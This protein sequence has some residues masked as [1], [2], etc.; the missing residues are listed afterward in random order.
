MRLLLLLLTAQPL[1]LPSGVHGSASYS[2]GRP[3]HKKGKF[4]VAQRDV[5]TATTSWLR[6]HS[7]EIST[8]IFGLS[9]RKDTGREVTQVQRPVTATQEP[10]V[11]ETPPTKEAEEENVP[12]LVEV[13][14]SLEIA[15]NDYLVDLKKELTMA[16]QRRNET[17]MVTILNHFGPNSRDKWLG[18]LLLQ[19]L[20]D[21]LAELSGAELGF[22]VMSMA[23]SEIRAASVW[24]MLAEA[25]IEAALIETY[26]RSL[27]E[28]A[29]GFAWVQWQQPDLFAVL[30]V[31]MGFCKEKATEEQKRA[32]AWSCSRAQQ[33]CTRLFGKPSPKVD[34]SVASKFWNTLTGL[35]SAKS[36]A[37]TLILDPL[38]VLLLPEAVPARHCDALVQLA[39]V[40]KLWM[41][42][43]QL[44]ASND[45]AT[46]QEILRTSRTSSTALLAWHES[47]PS[48][49]AVREWAARTLQVPEDFIEPLQLERYT[50]GQKFGKHTDWIGEKHPGLWAFGQRM[51]TLHVYL[52]TVPKGAGGETSFPELKVEVSPQKGSAILWPN[53]DATGTPEKKVLH[54]ALP[55]NGNQVKYAM[56]IWVRGRSQPD[57]TW[58][59]WHRS[60]A[61]S[62]ALCKVANPD[63]TV[64]MVSPS[65]K[66]I[67]ARAQLCDCNLTTPGVGQYTLPSVSF[68]EVVE[69]GGSQTGGWKYAE[70]KMFMECLKQHR[71]KPTQHFFEHLYHEMPDLPRLDIVDHVH[72]LANYHFHLAQKQWNIDKYEDE[73]QAH[74]PWS[75]IISPWPLA[76]R[77]LQDLARAGACL[78]LVFQER[79]V[80]D[81]DLEEAFR[82]FGTIVSLHL[83]LNRMTGETKGYCMLE[84]ATFEE[85]SA[86]LAAMHGRDMK[87]SCMKVAWLCKEDG[88]DPGRAK[89]PFAA[90]QR[91]R[92]F[93][94]IQEQEQKEMM[95]RQEVLVERR[96]RD[97]LHAWADREER[98]LG[99]K[100]FEVKD[101][102]QP[103]QRFQ[104]E[105]LEAN[106]RGPHPGY[107]RAPGYTWCNSKER[108]DLQSRKMTDLSHVRSSSHLDGPGPGQYLGADLVAKCTSSRGSYAIVHDDICLAVLFGPA[109]TSGTLV[110]SGGPAQAA[111]MSSAEPPATEAEASAESDLQTARPSHDGAAELSGASEEEVHTGHTGEADAFESERLQPVAQSAHAAAQAAEMSSAEPPA[112]EAEASAESDLQTARPS[113][114]GVAAGLETFELLGQSGDPDGVVGSSDGTQEF[115]Q[116]TSQHRI[117]EDD[118][119]CDG[120]GARNDVL[121]LAHRVAG[122]MAD[123]LARCD[124]ASILVVLAW[125]QLSREKSPRPRP[126]FARAFTLRLGSLG[127]ET[128]RT[129]AWAIRWFELQRHLNRARSLALAAARKHHAVDNATS[130][131]SHLLEAA[132]WVVRWFEVYRK[133]HIARQA[134]LYVARTQ[135]AASR[136]PGGIVSNY[137]VTATWALR[138]FELNR[139]RYDVSRFVVFAGQ[140]AHVG[141]RA[142]AVSWALRWFQWQSQRGQRRRRADQLAQKYA[143]TLGDAG[144]ALAAGWFRS[145]RH[146]MERKQAADAMAKK[147]A[148]MLNTSVQAVAMSWFEHFRIIQTD[149]R[150]A[151]GVDAAADRRRKLANSL[152]KRSGGDA[153]LVARSWYRSWNLARWA[154]RFQQRLATMPSAAGS[155]CMMSVV[156]QHWRFLCASSGMAGT[157]GSRR[158]RWR[159]LFLADHAEGDSSAIAGMKSKQAGLARGRCTF[160]KVISRLR[161]DAAATELALRVWQA[162]SYETAKTRAF[163]V[164]EEAI[165]LRDDGL[166]LCARVARQREMMGP[167]WMQPSKPE[168]KPGSVAHATAQSSGGGQE[169]ARDD[170]G[171]AWIRHVA[172]SRME[173]CKGDL[174]L[175]RANYKLALEEH[176]AALDAAGVKYQASLEKKK[177]ELNEVQ[178]RYLTATASRNE[179]GEALESQLSLAEEQSVMMAEEKYQRE[180][181]RYEASLETLALRQRLTE[182]R[183][184]AEAQAAQDNEALVMQRH[185]ASLKAMEQKHQLSLKTAEQK[186]ARALEK[187]RLELE[188]KYKNEAEKRHQA[189]LD[190]VFM[191]IER[192][193]AELVR[194]QVVLQGLMLGEWHEGCQR[195]VSRAMRCQVAH[196]TLQPLRNAEID[197]L[198]SSSQQ[199][200]ELL[201]RQHGGHVEEARR[202]AHLE[203]QQQFQMAL[204][205][206][207]VMIQQALERHRADLE[208][209]Y[210]DALMRKEQENAKLAS[211]CSTLETELTAFEKKAKT[212]LETSLEVSQQHHHAAS[213]LAAERHALTLAERQLKADE[214]YEAQK[215]V[216]E[217]QQALLCDAE[218]KLLEEK[219]AS[220]QKLQEA[221]ANCEKDLRESHESTC[222][223]MAEDHQNEVVRLEAAL[224]AGQIKYHLSIEKYT[225]VLEATRQKHDKAMELL[226]K[227]LEEKH[228]TSISDMDHRYSHAMLQCE[229]VAESAETRLELVEEKFT[230]EVESLEELNELQMISMKTDL[231]ERHAAAVSSAQQHKL[232]EAEQTWMRE[233]QELS[234]EASE[235]RE[236]NSVQRLTKELEAA[237]LKY[238]LALERHEGELADLK[239]QHETVLK[240]RETA[241]EAL[242]AKLKQ[243]ELRHGKAMEAAEAKFRK[244]IDRVKRCAIEEARQQILEHRRRCKACQQEPL[245]LELR[246]ASAT[247]KPKPA[248]A[249][250][251]DPEPQLEPRIREVVPLDPKLVE[252]TLES[253]MVERSR[254]WIWAQDMQRTVDHGIEGILEL[255]E[256][257]LL[258]LEQAARHSLLQGQEDPRAESRIAAVKQLVARVGQVNEELGKL[259]SDRAEFWYTL[260]ETSE[261]A[262]HFLRQANSLPAPGPAVVKRLDF[263]IEELCDDQKKMAEAFSELA[264]RLKA[265]GQ[266]QGRDQLGEVV[267]FELPS[268]DGGSLESLQEAR[269]SLPTGAHGSQEAA[270]LDEAGA[271]AQKLLESSREVVTALLADVRDLFYLVDGS[272][273]RPRL[274]PH[275]ALSAPAPSAP[276][277]ETDA[278]QIIHPMLEPPDLRQTYEMP[279]WRQSPGSASF[280]R[281]LQLVQNATPEKQKKLEEHPRSTGEA[282]LLI[283]DLELA[284]SAGHSLAGQA[285]QGICCYLNSMALN[286]G[287]GGAA[288]RWR[289]FE[290]LL[291][292]VKLQRKKDCHEEQSRLLKQSP[293]YIFGLKKPA[294]KIVGPSLNGPGYTGPDHAWDRLSKDLAVIS[295][296][297]NKP[298]WRFGKELARYPLQLELS[299]PPEVGPGMYESTKGLHT[300]FPS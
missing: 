211:R 236:Q 147:Y 170:G 34:T 77:S 131:V 26:P 142:V 240:S 121:L 190:E 153:L 79:Q 144:R 208:S 282:K 140:M 14:E 2:F 200:E 113:H 29:F 272:N 68:P 275:P 220:V 100:R 43:S 196:V 219:E 11:Q 273:L 157:R 41:N 18:S 261:E 293:S 291:V 169:A 3:T 136:K 178:Q 53:V 98:R 210:H 218:E 250:P 114:D 243:T 188:M 86:A 198:R 109:N 156:V 174:D 22:L 266:G 71:H 214:R 123:R 148:W 288:S 146:W 87:G 269:S 255:H 281:A 141:N 60:L 159:R 228:I 37:K 274:R 268:L 51:A 263:E 50:P 117:R 115:G 47:H 101:E 194:T 7:F 111:E 151:A 173:K 67:T 160:E 248:A 256:A 185:T 75:Q 225:N 132:F 193:R 99:Q 167:P 203:A 195:S 96:K 264:L 52:N 124:P 45:R 91:T 36:N 63:L 245:P 21:I 135:H 107:K 12:S 143:A 110:C 155:W 253:L 154:E 230:N 267:H 27:A 247:P 83:P 183:L 94:S 85:A 49:R 134:A 42:S 93:P 168:I 171:K 163:R 271:D 279:A 231:E 284:R 199:Q 182:D 33:P 97:E 254:S 17:S 202:A 128:W 277:I 119:D 207:E 64:A 103:H 280:V 213:Q 201:S 9:A 116:K 223:K 137:L 82:P 104:G 23:Y 197:D 88:D 184:S 265:A 69:H 221:V 249:K 59:K 138:W 297:Q 176:T 16:S 251:R 179:A 161:L 175:T 25:A 133:V 8:N 260:H 292:P 237:K 108:R 262:V 258:L 76:L 30:Q 165:G 191:T 122:Y 209:R 257:M 187:H 298:S 6:F 270:A 192:Q 205:Q 10:P 102:F 112:T 238:Q 89:K 19:A 224:E 125:F 105:V 285:G 74:A 1:Q 92:K 186:I 62:N 81:D 152:G 84:Y 158:A 177:A 239:F 289:N 286:D 56:N 65:R 24:R 234:E 222:E 66:Q 28:L 162:W 217:K 145:W 181:M 32:F 278:R 226:R 233:K 80:E 44:I 31:A 299:S 20:K 242:A 180:A 232:M 95:H 54:E 39:D 73:K 120:I 38:P 283:W 164:M 129:A 206:R 127:S 229:A 227:E 70:H 40:Q 4:K 290:T 295:H 139:Q 189:A 212:T 90:M 287:S 150:N 294:A 5:S 35:S 61:E 215:A 216:E 300:Q 48:V 244:T 46:R 118:F 57:Q 130:A 166:E 106:L 241:L 252:V 15:A 55:V 276:Q 204:I 246:A 235:R 13:E 149:R 259:R 58:I 296:H 78:S 72:W 172:L 126:D